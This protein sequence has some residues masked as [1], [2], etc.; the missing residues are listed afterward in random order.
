MVARNVRRMQRIVDDLLDLSR[1]ESGG[2]LPNP[3]EQDIEAIAAE[4]TAPLQAAATAKGVALRTEVAPEISLYADATA[5]RQILSNL[6]ENA[7][8]HTMTRRGRALRRA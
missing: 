7:L 1:I 8:R 4:V 2:W 3:V 6:A 5:T